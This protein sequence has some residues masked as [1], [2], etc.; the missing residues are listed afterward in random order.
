MYKYPFKSLLSVLLCIY[1]EVK[2]LDRIG[3]LCLWIMERFIVS[4]TQVFLREKLQSI[5]YSWL[6][7]TWASSTWDQA[8]VDKVDS[9]LPLSK[10][11][12]YKSHTR[13][14]IGF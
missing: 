8:S 1:P 3:C 9:E 14:L 6:E 11:L 5:E 13:C 10:T 4:S 12:K 2:L 7:N